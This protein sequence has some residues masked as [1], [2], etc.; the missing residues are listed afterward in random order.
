MSKRI[1]D[2][3]FRPSLHEGSYDICHCC[4][5]FDASFNASLAFPTYG[6]PTHLLSPC[7]GSISSLCS[8]GLPAHL[9][10]HLCLIGASTPGVPDRRHSLIGSTFLAGI[11]G[12]HHSLIRSA[13]LARVPGQHQ[14]LIAGPW[15]TGQL[16]ALTLL[17]Y[18]IYYPS[19][20][21][22]LWPYKGPEFPRV[23]IS[24]S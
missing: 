24:P 4:Q 2:C 22:T 6:L 16:N 21:C 9:D 19:A 23:L 13:S 7:P 20:V 14:S 11:T 18:I 17:G 3:T 1:N 10:W 8:H 12:R 15:P 5:R